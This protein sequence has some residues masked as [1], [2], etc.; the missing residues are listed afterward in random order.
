MGGLGKTTMSKS[1]CNH[2][3]NEFLGRVCYIE[4][5]NGG[6]DLERQR[7]VMMKL[8]RLDKDVLLQ[9]VSDISQVA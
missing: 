4:I 8:L 7:M 1:L 2:F 5:K 6:S 9:N 3:N